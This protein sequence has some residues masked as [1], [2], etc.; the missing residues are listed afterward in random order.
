M[1]K[2]LNTSPSKVKLVHPETKVVHEFTLEHAQRM[3]QYQAKRNHSVTQAWM[4]SEKE[5]KFIIKDGKIVANSDIR[6]PE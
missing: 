5:T 1:G 3:I 6:N 2:R 4:V